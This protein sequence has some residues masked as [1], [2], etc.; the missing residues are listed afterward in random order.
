LEAQVEARLLMLSHTNLLSPA[1]GDPISVPSQDM[2]LGLYILTI[3]NHQGIYG[4][5]E[6]LPKFNCSYRSR[7]SSKKIPY[8]YGYDNVV[9]VREQKKI[10]LHSPLWLRWGTNLRVNML[11]ADKAEPKSTLKL[12]SINGEYSHES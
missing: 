6:N 9:I 10:S 11:S 12:I 5:R 4:N 8:F 3:E 1:M 7:V 2:L